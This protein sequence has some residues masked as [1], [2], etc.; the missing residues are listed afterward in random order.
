MKNKIWLPLSRNLKENG[1]D[2]LVNNS[3]E[4]KAEWSTVALRKM[5]TI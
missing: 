5:E 4:C 1:Q 3:L 2:N